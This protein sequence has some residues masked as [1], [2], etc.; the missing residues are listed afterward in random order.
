M[1]ISMHRFHSSADPVSCFRAALDPCRAPSSQVWKA[2]HGTWKFPHA[3]QMYPLTFL[4]AWMMWPPTTAP[5]GSQLVRSGSVLRSPW[6]RSQRFLWSPDLQSLPLLGRS[7]HC[8]HERLAPHEASDAGA[9]C[10]N[11]YIFYALLKFATLPS[12]LGSSFEDVSR[13]FAG[14]IG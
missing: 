5:R 4:C 10:W 13:R 1:P 11:L 8:G 12:L 2:I 9:S 3:V 14:G 6:R 7:C